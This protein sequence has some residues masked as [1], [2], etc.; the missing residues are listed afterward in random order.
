MTI[1]TLVAF[2][3]GWWK[4]SGCKAEAVR[5]EF[6]ITIEEYCEH[7]KS[8]LEWG[9]F[10]ELGPGDQTV[11]N[12]LRKL[13]EYRERRARGENVDVSIGYRSDTDGFRSSVI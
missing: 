7:A 2:E 9:P 3:R 8:L 1:E 6:G 4:R 5:D 10:P 13:L 11:L 12:R